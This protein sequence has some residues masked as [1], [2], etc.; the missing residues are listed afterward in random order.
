MNA[1]NGF[2]L[3]SLASLFGGPAPEGDVYTVPTRDFRI[4]V[5]ID[6]ARRAE[7]RQ[8]HLY[9][10]TDQGKTWKRAVTVRPTDEAFVYTAPRDGVYWFAVQT[11]DPKGRAEPADP[12]RAE[13][14]LKIH[15]DTSGKSTPAPVKER[16]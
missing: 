1:V 4:P 11:V 3:F 12:R 10:S 2:F 9:V 8:L 14:M 7:V 13:S 15:V 5:Q 6:P 16:E